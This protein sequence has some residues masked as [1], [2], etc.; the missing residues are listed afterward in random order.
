M[1][2]FVFLGT[3]EL[4]DDNLS[5]YVSV[6]VWGGCLYVCVDKC[7]TLELLQVLFIQCDPPETVPS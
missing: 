2:S 6:C 7:E 3:P 4:E 1:T 5:V